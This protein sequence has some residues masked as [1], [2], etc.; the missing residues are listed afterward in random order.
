MVRIYFGKPGCGK[1]TKFAQIAFL[2]SKAIDQGK[3]RY[4]FIIGNVALYGIPHYYLI[5][6]DTLGMIGYPDALVLVD[7][8]SIF[9]DSRAWHDNKNNKNLFLEY[10][11]LHRHWGNDVFFFTQIW[12][13]LDKTIR[14]VA[15]EVIYLHR[16]FILR[17]MTR[18]TR[19]GY[20]V[21]IPAAGQDHPGEIIMGYIKPGRL[22]QVFEPRFWRFPYY[23]YFDTLERPDLPLF[24]CDELGTLSLDRV[25][26]DSPGL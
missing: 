4:R 12:N 11:L 25:Y 19:I 10:I 24:P 7:E 22:A 14:D 2:T 23:K 5:S 9:A 6:P 20:G 16:G 26:I 18:E 1:T 13:R 8:G 21:I 15:N 17:G 3:S